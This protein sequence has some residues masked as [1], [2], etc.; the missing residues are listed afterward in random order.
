MFSVAGEVS[1]KDPSMVSIVRVSTDLVQD[2]ESQ[3]RKKAVLKGTLRGVQL[4]NTKST[5]PLG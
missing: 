4:L 2:A 1:V 5:V 3:G